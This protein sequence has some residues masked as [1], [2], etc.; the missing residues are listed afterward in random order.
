VTPWNRFLEREVD[1]PEVFSDW[2][3]RGVGGR[4]SCAGSSVPV[5]RSPGWVPGELEIIGLVSLVDGSHVYRVFPADVAV[6]HA[7]LLTLVSDCY[8][9]QNEVDRIQAI[10]HVRSEPGRHSV[11]IMISKLKKKEINGITQD[12][13]QELYASSR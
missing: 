8:T 11:V 7:Y 3:P 5:E 13:W 2:E 12:G 1:L 9:R 10:N 6:S 4:E